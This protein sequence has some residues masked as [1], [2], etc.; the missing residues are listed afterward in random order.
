MARRGLPSVI[1]SDNATNFLG[2]RNELKEL[3][4]FLRNS[5]NLNTIKG[6]LNEFYIKWKF[7]PPRS[8]HWGGLWESNIKSAKH[9]LKRI[10]GSTPLTY[11]QFDTVISQIEAILNSRPLCPF[12]ND[13]SDLSSLTPG[14]FLIGK[15]LISYPDK[16]VSEV[17]QNRLKFYQ[18][19]TQMRQHFWKRWSVEYLNLLQKR[20]KWL[21]PQKNLEVGDLVLMKDELSI[22]LKWPLA[23]I[24]E[25]FP[26]PDHKVRVVKL[27]T[28]TGVLTRSISKICPLPKYE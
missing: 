14:H 1:L 11:E 22:P 18:Q 8:P 2:A 13:P 15:P 20:P 28:S 19:V 23:R 10:V 6:F 3:H 7:I 4:S 26:G 9:H 5:Q 27:R 17:P 25:V 16:D 21:A 12:S 24:V